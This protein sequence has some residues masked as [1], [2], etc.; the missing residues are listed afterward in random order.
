[1][2][3]GLDR[4]DPI[5]YRK[6]YYQANKEKQLARMKEYYQ[7]NRDKCLAATKA[8]I[9]ANKER[10][11]Q[12]KAEYHKNNKALITERHKK[13]L[14]NLKET[15]PEKVKAMHK[16]DYIKYKEYYDKLNN[17][18]SKKRVQELPD[19]Y[20]RQVLMWNTDK[21]IEIPQMLIEAKRLEI[22]IKRRV[23]NEISNN[24]T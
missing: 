6:A 9:D 18:A 14:K 16:A 12:C 10:V 22:L 20:I 24:I 11:K 21:N 1:M 5:A 17:A 3:T 13:W 19:A 15:N 23:K 4:S 8:W 2:K 7:A